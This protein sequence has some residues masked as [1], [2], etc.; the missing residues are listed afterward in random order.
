ML[1]HG[2]LGHLQAAAPQGIQAGYLRHKPFILRAATD[3]HEYLRLELMHPGLGALRNDLENQWE[4][5]KAEWYSGSE[6]RL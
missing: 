5:K 4:Y 2:E 6:L 1:C 3:D